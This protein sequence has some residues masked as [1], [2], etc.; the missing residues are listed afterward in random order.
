MA[1]D[2]WYVMTDGRTY[3]P[4]SSAMLK[5]LADEGDVTVDSLVRRGAAG[6]WTPAY[7]VKG[8]DLSVGPAQRCPPAPRQEPSIPIPDSLNCPHCGSD[9]TQKL[10]VIYEAGTSVATTKSTGSGVILTGG[11]DFAPVFTRGTSTRLEQTQLALRSRPPEMRPL[12]TD[13]TLIATCLT[14]VIYFPFLLIGMS[15]LSPLDP[16]ESLW[17]F[18]VCVTACVWIPIPLFVHRHFSRQ[19]PVVERKRTEIAES[20][21][22]RMI[23]WNNSYCCHK[24]GTMF[25]PGSCEG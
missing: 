7:R 17:L 8:L 5:R 10:S 23:A 1:N 16:S 24:C 2:E 22:D 13:Q 19:R 12:P 20:N 14:C 15:M 9:Q 25:I 18:T 6:K 3:G 21:R 4:M 11:G